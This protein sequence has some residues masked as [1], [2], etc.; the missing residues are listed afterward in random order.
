ME[1]LTTLGYKCLRRPIFLH[2]S[3]T[4]IATDSLTLHPARANARGRTQ[5]PSDATVKPATDTTAK[6]TVRWSRTRPSS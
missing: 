4:T 2:G 3:L 6:P 5:P 1:Q